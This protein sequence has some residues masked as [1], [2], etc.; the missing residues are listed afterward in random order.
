MQGSR[1]HRA[2]DEV[3]LR[4]IQARRNIRDGDLPCRKN[5]N[6][7]LYAARQAGVTEVG[8]VVTH[9]RKNMDEQHSEVASKDDQEVSGSISNNLIENTWH[10]PSTHMTLT[11]RR[12]HEGKE[13]RAICRGERVGLCGADTK[14]RKRAYR[15]STKVQCG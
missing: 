9:G 15:T 13:G 2:I 4:R 7:I 11:F 5:L 10:A 8:L 6:L 3:T 1:Y 14:W 12:E